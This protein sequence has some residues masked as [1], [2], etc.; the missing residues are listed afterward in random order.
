MLITSLNNDKIKDYIKLKDKKYRKMNKLFIIEGEHLVLEAYKKN[1]LKELILLDETVLSAE[2][3]VN[4]TYVTKEIMNKLTDLETPPNI[5]G[6]CEIKEESKLVGD[7]FLL[8]DNVQDPGNLGTIIRSA[9][10]FNID[11]IILSKDTVDL[12]NPKVV[13]STQGIMFHINII[14]ADLE[15]VINDLKKK[16]IK[17]FGTDVETGMTPSSIPSTDKEKFALVMGNEGNGVKDSIKSMC[18]ENLYI[19]MNNE[20]ESLNVAVATSII[21]YEMNRR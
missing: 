15:E 21:L 7:R 3:N 6:I 19:K 4:T 10:A 17:I 5:L 12:Y 11:T 9:K 18:D 16:G 2:I 14:Y 20:V 1:L 8:L 13:R